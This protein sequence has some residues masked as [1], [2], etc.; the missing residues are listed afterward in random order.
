M[1]RLDLQ[2][3]ALFMT[4]LCGAFLGGLADV[5][6]VARGYY[7]PG[8]VLGALADLAFWTVATAA[9]S[10]ALFYGNWGQIRLYVLVGLLAGIGLYFWLAGPTVRGL[11]RLLLRAL[12]WLGRLLVW[13]VVRLLWAPVALAAGFTW[14]LVSRAGR[15]L[16]RLLTGLLGGLLM[17]LFWPL[18][19]LYRWTRLRYLLCKR[20]VK[21]R[22][23]DW[24]LGPPRRRRR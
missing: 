12:S 10:G 23:R 5:L 22:L 13:V 15:L 11:T 24:I 8:R 17:R 14:N 16:L 7:R 20:R 3:Y 21:R 9:V 2:F 6:R 19:R 4:V 18:R 1:L